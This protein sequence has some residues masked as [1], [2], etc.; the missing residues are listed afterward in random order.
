MMPIVCQLRRR[1]ACPSDSHC[2]RDLLA[3]SNSPTDA[4]IE[5]LMKIDLVSDL[6]DERAAV[7]R[8]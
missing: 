8:D 4:V 3:T 2:S 7:K 6:T 5:Q 1:D